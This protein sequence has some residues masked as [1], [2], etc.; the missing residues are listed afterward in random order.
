MTLSRRSVAFGLR[1][2]DRNRG[3]VDRL[4]K[5]HQRDR[6][7]RSSLSQNYEGSSK[8]WRRWGWRIVR[9]LFEN[10][11]HNC[12]VVHSVTDDDSSV[13]KNLTHS[14]KELLA[15]LRI[16]SEECS[17]YAK[18]GKEAWQ[19]Y[20]AVTAS[21]SSS[22]TKAIESADTHV[23]FFAKPVKSVITGCGCKVD[24]E[25]MKRRLSWTFVHCLGTYEHLNRRTCRP[26]TSFDN[27]I[28]WRLVRVGD[29][30]GRRRRERLR[31]APKCAIKNL[32]CYETTMNTHETNANYS[33]S[34]TQHCRGVQ[35]N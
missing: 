29:R 25:R 35:Q 24:A 1:A 28:L 11:K 34:T 26:W 18:L 2:A 6:A 33:I 22:S 12:Y 8:G 4:Y 15:A 30:D 21:K 23:F 5:M 7:R 14:F 19:R 16:T 32:P 17:K 20:V 9:R 3:N 31:F 10:F 13:R 27:P